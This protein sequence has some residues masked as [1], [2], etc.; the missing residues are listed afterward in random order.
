MKRGMIGL[1]AVLVLFAGL[2]GAEIFSD[3]NQS[4]FNL[5]VYLNTIHNGTG[6]I[7][8]GSNLSG[9][10]TSRV[11]DAGTVA[12]W[13]NLSYS[14]SMPSEEYLY[15]VDVNADVWKS[16]NSG[17]NWTLVKDDYNGA[18]GQNA[19]VSAINNNGSIFIIEGDQDV[20]KSNNSGV[21]WSKVAVNFNEGNSVVEGMIVDLQNIL[22]AVD[23]NA[24]V[25]K[26]NNSGVNW[27]LVKDDYNGAEGNNADGMIID[28]NGI[29]YVLDTPAVWK[30]NNSGV[31]WSK[32]SVDFND[33]D[34]H[35]GLRIGGGM[36]NSIYIVDSNEDVFVSFNGGINFSSQVINFN[37]GNSNVAGILAIIINTNL[38][39]EIRNCSSSDCSDGSWQTSDLNNINASGRYF[40]Y[41]SSLARED[42]DIS[43]IL[44]SVSL[45]Y[46]II[47]RVPLT[48]I[49][50][51]VNISYNTIQ[52]RLNYSVS[53]VD[54]NIQS[55]WYSADNGQTN[56]TI[57]CGQ[58]ITGLSSA[59][60]SNTWNV[61]VNDSYGLVN[62]SQVIFFVD[63]IYPV[64]NISFPTNGTGANINNVDINYSV[65]DTNLRSCW[66][67][68]DNGQTN[69]TITCGQNI[70]G[71]TWD[72]GQINVIVWANDTL[73]NTN[74]SRIMFFVDSISPIVSID[75]P[76]E[77]DTYGT[78]ENLVLNFSV[79]DTNLQNCWYNLDD[80]TNVSL[81]LC[82]NAV[83]NVSEGSHKLIVFANDS[84]NNIGAESKNFSVNL[85]A[86]SI[87][88]LAPNGNYV[89]LSNIIFSYITTDFDLQTCELWGDFTGVFELN[90]TDNNVV[91][92]AN[93]EFL[94][95]LN[96]GNYIWNV[97]CNDSQGHYAFNGNKTF[98]VDTTFPQISL[99]EPASIKSSRANIQL[100]YEINDTNFNTCWFN[101]LRG[102]NLE[103]VNTSLNC[104]AESA[105]FSVSVDAD[106][107]VNV[108]ANDSA[109]NVNV[110]SLS[111][112]VDTATTGGTSG[113]DS[114]GG[115]SGG[116][117]SGGG[118]FVSASS[119]GKLELQEMG[120]ILLRAGEVKKE[121]LS[122]K[123]KGSTYL[124]GC[125]LN[126]PDEFSSWIERVGSFK[127]GGGEKLE[128]PF[129]IKVPVD[130]KPGE[131]SIELNLSCDESKN[132]QF[133]KL[134]ILEKKID[135]RI[136]SV[137]ADEKLI[138]ISYSI[139]ELSGK[140]QKVN[141]KFSFFDSK[142]NNKVLEY[143]DSKTIGSKESFDFE[144]II[145]SN[146]I[147][148]ENYKLLIGISSDREST[149][150]QEDII[151]GGKLSGFSVLGIGNKSGK[152]TWGLI[153]GLGA[154]ILVMAVRIFYL[155]KKLKVRSSVKIRT[156]KL[157]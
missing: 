12:R 55:C 8:S 110:T 130:V 39:L 68:A 81:P 90:Q 25:W 73:G 48:S 1:L 106:F 35:N 134:E 43:P 15:A 91:S 157:R 77:G 74:S 44:Y 126:V 26:S 6:V 121:T 83:F 62:F 155:K 29:I 89:N 147:L 52:T 103:I 156:V 125:T 84:I 149:F 140:E 16:N 2:V 28:E 118:S 104:S 139:S 124:N 31:N 58:N 129:E 40:Q 3:I 13:N 42:A 59:E 123:N 133:L 142:N 96:D 141:L 85:L 76:N 152:L 14:G 72:E 36:N 66:Y 135:F 127:L 61:W 21:N 100:A 113:G 64:I 67:S 34:T 30:S 50:Y 102:N 79:S 132:S 122:L 32:V 56:T 88:L 116:G 24:D 49:V 65:L 154:F 53:D 51:P 47:N 60:G 69:T 23:V 18:E 70:T 97:R 57:T 144:S 9:A 20:W 5:G 22:Y 98:T 92:G 45:N 117:S 41:K 10:F 146:L 109:G 87:S 150:V 75:I 86:P 145:P 136:N 105:S 131:Y 63:S 17:V 94:L 4:N 33:G 114:G 80:G 27:T 37:G 148:G 108:Y 82:A 71:Q 38:T 19:D 11:F 151:I 54:G 128:I 78:N 143:V 107:I 138:R 120:V 101:V 153:I 115:S 7:L 111:F 112:S 95:N 137:N 46:E 93:S 99:S 119:G